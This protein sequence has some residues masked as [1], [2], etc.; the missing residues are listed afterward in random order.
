MMQKIWICGANGML[1][2][3]FKV[4]CEK[5]KIS[6]IAT[7]RQ[8]IDITELDAV[9]EFTRKQKISHIV[10]CAAYTN[11]DQA[12]HEPSNAYRS[13]A[14]GPHNLGIAARRHGARVIHFSTD[15]VF[16]GKQ[17]TPYTEEDTCSP[18]SAYGLS[19][20]AGEVKLLNEHKNVCLIRSSW[21]FGDVGRNFVSTILGLLSEKNE[22]D[23]VSDQVG[24]PTYCQDLA[25]A[26]LK[27]L[28]VNGIFHFANNNETSWYKYALEI[29]NQAKAL[30]FPIKTQIIR[31]IPSTEYLSATQRPAYSSLDTKKFQEQF[32]YKAPRPW[33]LALQE[34][35]TNLKNMSQ[36]QE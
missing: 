26:A 30:H 5:L 16:D 27:L 7:N 6:Y 9:S 21:L 28:D 4:L 32:G 36:K 13:N 23:V 18:Q 12:E 1:G 31:P 14:M 3:H 15:Y 29:F 34:C 24:R 11:V 25:E 10:N 35:L 19:K 17:K 20:L 33:P 8:Q 2:S 22:I